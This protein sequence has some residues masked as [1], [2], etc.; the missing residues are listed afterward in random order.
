MPNPPVPPGATAVAPAPPKREVAGAGVD[1][2][3]PNNPGP[4]AGAPAPPPNRLVE[5]VPPLPKGLVEAAG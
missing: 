1:V 2:V 4:A 3:L 5:A